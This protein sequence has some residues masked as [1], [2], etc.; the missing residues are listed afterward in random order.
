MELV[1]KLKIIVFL[2][3]AKKQ[4]EE[5][6]WRQLGMYYCIFLKGHCLGKELRLVRSKK[7]MIKLQ[8]LR[9][10]L[11]LRIFVKEYQVFTKGNDNDNLN[12][13]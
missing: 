1:I 6:T 10:A 4:A 3:F 2:L 13:F 7:S 11:L 12:I 5:M 9:I 8:M